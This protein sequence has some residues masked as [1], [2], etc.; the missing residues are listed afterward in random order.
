MHALSVGT[1]GSFNPGPSWQIKGSGDF[2][3]D[4]RDDIL[5]QGS[6]GTPA[7]WLMDGM[8]ALSV[9]AA[10][11]FNPGPSWQIKGTTTSM[12]T[13]G[14]TSCGRAATARRQSG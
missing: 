7:I 5:W 10:G 8:H 11:S 12:A 9:G 3:G 13:A 4:G 6:D 14:L 2:N 1:A